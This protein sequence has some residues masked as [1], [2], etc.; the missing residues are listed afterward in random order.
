MYIYADPQ[1]KTFE[2][3]DSMNILDAIAVSNGKGAI[4]LTD[5]SAEHTD[6]SNLSDDEVKDLMANSIA[7]KDGN[8]S[9]LGRQVLNNSNFR[10]FID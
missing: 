3:I 1:N 7:W 2:V 8:L 5:D 10:N 4:Y 9:N 6:A